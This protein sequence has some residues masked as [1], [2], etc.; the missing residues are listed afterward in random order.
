MASHEC[1]IIYKT[2]NYFI[3]AEQRT[4]ESSPVKSPQTRKPR[5]KP[6]LP[7]VTGI[8]PVPSPEALASQ[9]PREGQHIQGFYLV[10]T[11]QEC[12]IFFSW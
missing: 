9:K 4:S 8:H 3:P 7:V 2:K 1:I 6:S 5:A 12:G 10:T 11:G